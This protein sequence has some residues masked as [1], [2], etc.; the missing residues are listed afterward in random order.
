QKEPI[1]PLLE[2][3]AQKDP[4]VEFILIEARGKA[5]VAGADV[6]FFVSSLDRG[7]I[8]GIVGFT[9]F[10]HEV[11]RRIET[12][13]KPVAAVLEAAALGGGAELALACRW[14]L[15]T[16]KALFLFPE[17]G[18]G[19]YPGLGGTQRLSR[20]IGRELAKHFILSGAPISASAAAALGLVDRIIAP[21]GAVQAARALARGEKSARGV[22]PSELA[23]LR[24]RYKDGALA[25]TIAQLKRK[26]PLAL[27]AAN[28]LIDLGSRGSLEEG[29]KLELSRLKEIFS[30][31]DAREGLTA[32]LERRP[33]AFEGR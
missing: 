13:P 14:R 11:L 25:Q 2:Q 28:E 3:A 29:L 8:D 20:L 21:G 6:K 17:T 9:E 19:I 7:D 33:A 24:E 22:E 10:G 4:G 15:A 30:T 23:G 16:E 5:F 26:A 1:K 32:L 12:S 31:R 27:K 18:L